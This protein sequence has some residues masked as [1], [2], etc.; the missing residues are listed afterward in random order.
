MKKIAIILSVVMACI[1]TSC[2]K[3]FEE[4]NAIALDNYEVNLPKSVSDTS[5]PVHY[6]HISSNGNWTAKLELADDATTWCWLQEYYID[7]KGN[8]VNVATPVSAFEGMEEEGRWNQVKGSGT[9]YLP[10]RFLTASANRYGVLIVTN[11]DT[12]DQV[13]MR[14]T[15][16]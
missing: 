14:I 6:A 5:E 10:I 2:V 11:T 12:G 4:P 15:Q 9:V 13:I 8:Q 3:P 16:K 1:A 7:A